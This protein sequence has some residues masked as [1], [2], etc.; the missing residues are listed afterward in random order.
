MDFTADLDDLLWHWGSAYLISYGRAGGWIARRR[1]GGG[2]V[3]ADSAS[4]LLT[5]IRQDYS[6]CAVRR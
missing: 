6:A 5:E 2:S 1:D 4:V 3:R